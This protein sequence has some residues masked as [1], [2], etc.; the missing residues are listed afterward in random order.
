MKI[1][2]D[3]V[4]DLVGRRAALLLSLTVRAHWGTPSYDD[5]VE[6]W[7]AELV[8]VEA[9]LVKLGLL[10][11]AGEE[12]E[13][14]EPNAGEAEPAEVVTLRGRNFH[15]EAEAMEG[16]A[17]RQPC[18]FCDDTGERLVDMEVDGFVYE[19]VIDCLHA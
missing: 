3:E 9:E 11:I 10:K 4:I 5:Q 15:M 8:E 19:V 7:K 2:P 17:S 16:S 14:H 12:G 18:T 6:G 13:D 1:T